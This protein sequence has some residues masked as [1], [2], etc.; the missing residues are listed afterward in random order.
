MST[1]R[2]NPPT[3]AYTPRGEPRESRAI[4][5]T[6]RPGDALVR[7]VCLEPRPS[8]GGAFLLDTG[9]QPGATRPDEKSYQSGVVS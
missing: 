5:R 1:G 7:L 8:A 9:R 3:A 2:L 4:D 6:A